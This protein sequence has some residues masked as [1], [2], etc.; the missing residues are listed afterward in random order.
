MLAEIGAPPEPPVRPLEDPAD[1]AFLARDDAWLVFGGHRRE[2]VLPQLE[3]ALRKRLAGIARADR[4]EELLY[5]LKKGLGNAFKRGNR[6]DL[7][8]WITT[9]VVMTSEGALVS[10]SDQGAGF[11]VERTVETLRRNGRYF[12]HG[13]SGLSHFDR[14]AT[15]V[16]YA[17]GGRTLLLRFL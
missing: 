6:G 3:V 10:V 9:E 15:L 1:P 12:E 2:D 16:S 4:A 17:D 5:L 14:S 7:A 11:D 8:K 13:G